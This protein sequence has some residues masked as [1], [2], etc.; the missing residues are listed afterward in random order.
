MNRYIVKNRFMSHESILFQQ[1]SQQKAKMNRFTVLESQNWLHTIQDQGAWHER[2]LPQNKLKEGNRSPP[3]LPSIKKWFI[4]G[5]WEK[6]WKMFG[7]KSASKAA[8]DPI[9]KPLHLKIFH[10]RSYV[11]CLSIFLI[12]RRLAARSAVYLRHSS[13]KFSSSARSVFCGLSN[14]G[15]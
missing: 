15:G 6:R 5:G 7:T 9:W 10:S 4:M 2:R 8:N 11:N 1:T 13:F 3:L 14:N 12:H